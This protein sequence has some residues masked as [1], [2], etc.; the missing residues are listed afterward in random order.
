MIYSRPL[1]YLTWTAQ[2]TDGKEH[3]A[4]FYF[5]ASGEIVVN[6][7]A[8]IVA[9]EKE[10][11]GDLT[12]LKLGSVEQAVLAKKGEEVTCGLIGVTSTL[13]RPLR[14]RMLRPHLPDGLKEFC[15]RPHRFRMDLANESRRSAARFST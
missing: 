13:P 2:A 15:G 5:D 14:Q 9:H 6:A 8:Q 7:G 4:A 3:E 11:G 1:T 10:Q 12:V